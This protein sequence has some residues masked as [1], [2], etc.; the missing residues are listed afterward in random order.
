[1]SF[2][3]VSC[4]RQEKTEEWL[5]K[6]SDVLLLLGDVSIEDE[7]FKQAIDDLAVCLD[8]QH[9]LLPAGDRRIAETYT[10]SHSCSLCN[11]LVYFRLFQMARAY[12]LQTVFDKAAEHYQLAADVIKKRIGWCCTGNMLHV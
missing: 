6:K 11:G 8:I 12:N 3:N 7:N 5:Q 2:L 9:K 4:F 1:M 10:Q